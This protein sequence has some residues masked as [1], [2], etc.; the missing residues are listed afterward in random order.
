MTTINNIIITSTELKIQY[1]GE[2]PPPKYK[3][4]NSYN[5]Y[6]STEQGATDLSTCQQN[7]IKPTPPKY[8][9]NSSY[10]CEESTEQ[11]ATDLSTCQQNCIKPSPP[12][13]SRIL[14]AWTETIGCGD[15]S[16]DVIS[17]GTA[18]PADYLIG[19]DKFFGGPFGPIEGFY[20]DIKD[21]KI[22]YYISIGGLNADTNDWA[23]F[24]NKLNTDEGLTDFINAC[25]CRNITGI[26]WDIE[27]F[28]DDLTTIL[29]TICINLKKAG[30]KIM[31]TILLGQPQWF[32]EL[33]SSKD[34]SY[35]DYVTLM[36]YNGGMYKAEGSG[37]GCDWDGWAELFLSNGT[38]GCKNPLKYA[39]NPV[40]TYMNNSNLQNINSKKIVLGLRNDESSDDN[41]PASLDTYIT[42]DE[43][44]KKYDSSGIFYWVLQFSTSTS[45]MDEVLE[46]IKRP[47]IEN[48]NKPDYEN[49]PPTSKPCNGSSS[50]CVA[51]FCAKL[52]QGVQDSDCTPC[53][54]S[55]TGYPC[56]H[57]GFCEEEL[58]YPGESCL[59]YIKT[60]KD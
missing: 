4:N 16:F 10:N 38:A 55:S 27:N 17:L 32:K 29:K 3:C 48:C 23:P 28:T 35:Y 7:C 33:F 40:Q 14:G 51:S 2:D 12:T 47:K 45:R 31:L 19:Y 49:C 24:L 43:L 8:K 30:F 11:G 57:P 39:T 56:G 22:D 25:K 42:A 34:D 44:V 60:I 1:K 54:S 15:T 37:A 20:E 59:K 58:T 9:C 36:L 50:S 46:H 5:C 52:K 41:N 21:A 53:I 13:P 26:D 6:E 18:L